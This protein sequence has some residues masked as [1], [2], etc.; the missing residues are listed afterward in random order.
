MTTT[1]DLLK[2]I[3]EQNKQIIEQNKQIIEQNKD[4]NKTMKYVELKS[5]L[6][7]EEINRR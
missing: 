3:I 7:L 5:N 2:T 4:T 6:I 1:N